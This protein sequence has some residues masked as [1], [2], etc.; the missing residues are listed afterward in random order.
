MSLLPRDNAPNAGS[1]LSIGVRAR[2]PL[3]VPRP[4]LFRPKPAEPQADETAEDTD[5]TPAPKAKPD[6]AKGYPKLVKVPLPPIP[7]RPRAKAGAIAKAGQTALGGPEGPVTQ[8]SALAPMPVPNRQATGIFSLFTTPQTA[9]DTDYSS[10]DSALLRPVAPAPAAAPAQAPVAAAALPAPAAATR[11]AIPRT[12]IKVLARLDIEDPFRKKRSLHPNSIDEETE[13]DD[14]FESG[15]VE[16]QIESVQINCLKP[17][18]MTIIK[19]AG[20]HFKTNPVITSGFRSSGRRGSLHRSCEA[21]DFFIPEVSS[22][23]LVG[24]LRK[25]PEAG[26]VGTYCHTKSV[27]IDIGDPRD[28]RYCGRGRSYFALRAPVTA[29]ARQ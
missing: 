4:E 20:E 1:L 29:A 15:K 21:A 16:K 13:D 24:Y 27:H 17:E 6:Y 7:D 9:T 23:E 28:W 18:L 10:G 5:E 8:V 25:L 3:P 11:S 12:E 2:V 14:D 22:S 26:G 19:K